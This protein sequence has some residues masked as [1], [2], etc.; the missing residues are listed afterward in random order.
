MFTVGPEYN[1]FLSKVMFNYFLIICAASWARFRLCFCNPGCWDFPFL[2]PLRETHS[3]LSINSAINWAII[4]DTGRENKGT[5]YPV[6]PRAGEEPWVSEQRPSLP[7]HGRKDLKP[8]RSVQL[9]VTE[10][11]RDTGWVGTVDNRTR[12]DLCTEPEY[13]AWDWEVFSDLDLGILFIYGSQ[14]LQRDDSDVKVS[15]DLPCASFYITRMWA[16]TEAEDVE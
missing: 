13:P 8:F 6:K 11:L 1:Y 4:K 5:M 15:P 12:L 3:T 2:S 9:W 7:E 14:T 16:D 10:G